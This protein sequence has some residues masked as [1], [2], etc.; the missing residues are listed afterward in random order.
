MKENNIL[1]LIVAYYLSKYNNAYHS[2]DYSTHNEAHKSIGSILDVK[3]RTI[4]NMRDE[5]DPIHNNERVGWYQRE[6]RPSRSRVVETFQNSSETELHNVVLSILDDS[7]FTVSEYYPVVF[8]LITKIQNNCNVDNSSLAEFLEGSLS[9]CESKVFTYLDFDPHY[10]FTHKERVSNSELDTF[11]DIIHELGYG[12]EPDIRYKKFLA[13]QTDNL[14]LFKV[15]SLPFSLS[16]EYKLNYILLYI[17]GIFAAYDSK[18]SAE[19]WE[20]LSVFIDTR[21]NLKQHEKV[22][23]HNCLKLIV[24]MEFSL[25]ELKHFLK[26]IPEYKNNELMDLIFDIILSDHIIHQREKYLLRRVYEL[27]E[28]DS[29]TPVRDIQKY[30]RMKKAEIKAIKEEEEPS[31]VIQSGEEIDRAFDNIFFS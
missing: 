19:E 9:D 24:R 17:I 25:A 12:L 13:K 6:L 1:A 27:L 3:P 2:L 28:I 11:S 5:F 22:R 18:V 29:T 30:A 20:D 16:S 4:S 31:L 14:I 15:D 8:P 23:L 26:Q 10:V 21:N 7:D